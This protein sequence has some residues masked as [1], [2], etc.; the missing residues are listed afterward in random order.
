M[1]KMKGDIH[2]HWA[3]ILF[4]G[5]LAVFFG[6]LALSMPGLGL[7]LFVLLFGAYALVDGFFAL[8]IGARV[9]SWFMILEGVIGILAGLY[10]LAF[11]ASAVVVFVMVVGIWAIVTGAFEIVAGIQIRK[12]IVNEIFLILAGLLSIIFGSMIFIY[13][14]IFASA[15]A[16]VIGI[17]SL[18]FG[19]FMIILALKFRKLKKSSKK[20]K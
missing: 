3:G 13:P 5:I 12:H 17:Y 4:R 6:I 20:K 14:L 8:F 19:S 11:T 16:I 7:T 18:I 15:V 9:K 10:V 2:K 1:M